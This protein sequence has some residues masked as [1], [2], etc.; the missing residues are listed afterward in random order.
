MKKL[1]AGFAC[2][3]DGYIEGPH[4]EHDWIKVDKEMNF[5][6]QARRYDTYLFG[7]RSY[8]ALKALGYPPSPGVRNYVFS[9]TL[10]EVDKGFTLVSGRVKDTVQR[11]KEEEGK[12]IA[13][14]GG[15]SLLASLLHERLVDELS[16][17][18]IPVLLGGGKPMV[19]LLHNRVWLTYVGARTYANGSIEVSYT[20]NYDGI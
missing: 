4:G 9:T 15:A 14:Y 12:D 1:V 16:I 13:V 5:A 17:V 11:M 10:T 18:F 3:V 19:E 20:V 8:E 7:R 2:S 6:D